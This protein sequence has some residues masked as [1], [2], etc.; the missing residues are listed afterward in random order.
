[1]PVPE[2]RRIYLL[3]LSLRIYL[4]YWI[5]AYE[6]FELHTFNIVTVLF[7]NVYN[8]HYKLCPWSFLCCIFCS[9][10]PLGSRCTFN[11]HL[12]QTEVSFVNSICTSRGG[13]HVNHVCE[14]VGNGMMVDLY[15]KA[16]LVG[17]MMAVVETGRLF[18]ALCVVGICR[19]SWCFFCK[20]GI[21][22]IYTLLKTVI[23]GGPLDWRVR[24]D[25]TRHFK[26]KC[27]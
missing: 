1:M 21:A 2:G 4:I 15:G 12:Q 10:I 7:S 17:Y 8:M 16:S 18:A 14:Q 22:Y 5:I 3:C 25:P 6:Y 11:K 20:H 26:T 27:I 19:I 13:T 23:S 24:V 9:K